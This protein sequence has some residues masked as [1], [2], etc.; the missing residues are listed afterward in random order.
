M[1]NKL[2]IA[3]FGLAILCTSQAWAGTAGPGWASRQGTPAQQ[4]EAGRN[5]DLATAKN[6]QANE[7]FM[8]KGMCKNLKLRH[9]E[10]FAGSAGGTH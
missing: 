4:T 1:G 10:M 6:C 2:T 3:V 5:Q 8:Q 7:Q 9:P